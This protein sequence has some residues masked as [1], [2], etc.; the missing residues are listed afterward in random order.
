[1]SSHK[2]KTICH[3]I[4]IQVV[5][6]LC[7][8]KLFYVYV[9][10]NCFM[11]MW[12]Q[13]VLCLCDGKLFY[14]YVMANCFMFMWWQIV[15]CLCDGK[16]FYVYVMAYCFMFMWWQIVLCLCD[17][18]LFYVYKNNKFVVEY[19]FLTTLVFIWY[20]YKISCWYILKYSLLSRFTYIYYVVYSDDHNGLVARWKF[21][22]LKKTR[23]VKQ[24]LATHK[25]QNIYSTF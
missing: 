4:N 8:G 2:H 11:F 6:F 22:N 14:V 1:L 16:L 19:N 21:W 5:L 10:A 15:L 25:Y 13:I 20:S 3:H 7:D 18:I 9:M 17:G 24:V 12:W 23:K